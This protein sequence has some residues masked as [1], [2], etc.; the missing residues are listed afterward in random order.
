MLLA[1][2]GS[3]VAAG[4]SPGVAADLPYKAAAA[5]PTPYDWNGFYVGGNAGVGWDHRDASIFNAATGAFLTSGG[6]NASGITGGGQFGFNYTFAPKWIAGLEADISAADL[7]STVTGAPGVGQRE[8]KTDYFG[9]VRGRAGYA[10]NNILLYGTGGFAWV[11]EQ[12]IRTQQIGTI[13]LATP[14][15][16][17]SAS[18]YGDGWVAGGGVEWGATQ[19]WTVRVEYLHFGIGSQSFTFPLA[20]QRV[21]GTTQLDLVRFGVNYKFGWNPM[22]R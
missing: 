6:T 17:E 22:G 11:H 10:W 19:N 7:D 16:V 14:G 13:N 15:T 8:N 1:F 9:T 4:A 5:A 18:S 2:A 3:I 20:G 12:M 21:D